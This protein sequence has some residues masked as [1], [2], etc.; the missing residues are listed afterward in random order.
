MLE[1][2]AKYTM[3]S[4]IEGIVDELLVLRNEVIDYRVILSKVITSTKDIPGSDYQEIVDILKRH[5]VPD[6]ALQQE[7]L[8]FKRYYIH[9]KKEK[10][11]EAERVRMTGMYQLLLLSFSHSSSLLLYSLLSSSLHI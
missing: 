11:L 5:D 4:M 1:T 10:I 3:N 6:D 8:A 7:L 2:R 9:E